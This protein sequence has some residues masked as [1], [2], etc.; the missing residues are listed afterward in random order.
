M[1]VIGLAMAAAVGYAFR[2]GPLAI[3][4]VDNPFGTPVL[5]GL[6]TFLASVGDALF[7]V[8]VAAGA[9]SMVT[10]YR[11]ATADG[12]EQIKWFAFAAVIA[13][14]GFGLTLLPSSGLR[15]VGWALGA[16]GLTALPIAIAVA[17]LRYR[18]YDIDVVIN[19][20]LVWLGL[21]GVL[22]GTYAAV[23]ALLQRLFVELTGNTS[24]AAVILT[25]LILAGLFTPIRKTLESAVDLRFKPR[26]VQALADADRPVTHADLDDAL[27][28]LRVR[29]D[30]LEDLD[31]SEAP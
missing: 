8:A 29:L 12:R 6:T 19:R 30:R 10:R 1:S 17:V 21:I 31:R 13:A 3:G 11:R 9:A 4:G 20:T 24:D 7:P 5:A 16:L 25:T 18:L 15:V 2:P 14:I 27:A 23:I 22:G 28:P 26:R